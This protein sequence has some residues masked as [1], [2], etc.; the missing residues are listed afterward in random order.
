MARGRQQ[1]W[2]CKKCKAEFSVQNMSPK[3]CCF[4][5][6]EAIGRAP[7]YELLVNFEEK[8]RE[9]DEVC[10]ELNP[11][12]NKHVELKV[13]YDEIMSYWQQQKRRGYISADEYRKFACKYDGASRCDK[14]CK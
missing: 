1:K 8:Q 14:N 10:K 13:K 3:V 11:V 6:S 4:C 5:G 9:L 2:I 7:S 12:Y